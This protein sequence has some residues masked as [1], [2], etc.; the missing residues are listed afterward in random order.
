MGST[1]LP[2]KT[3]ADLGGLPVVDR[4][5]ARVRS[6][7]LVDEVVLAI[8]DRAEDDVLASHLDA[9]GQRYV[10]GSSDDV[11]SRF[12]LAVGTEP[13]AD[14]IIRITADCPLID[15]DVIDEVIA[16][17][18]EAPA[19][20]YCSNTL[21]RTYPIG[22][23]TEVFSRAALERAAAEALLPRER[24]HVTPYLYQHPMEFRLRNVEAPGWATWPELRLTLDEAADLEMLRALAARIDT[25]AGLRDVL[26]ALRDAP[27]IA[28]I[29]GQVA[30][31]HTQK[32][33]SW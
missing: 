33:G 27:E 20:D 21:V 15:P 29:N 14:T 17:S 31:R 13:D 30:H 8:T 7:R 9:L 28:A 6:A 11:L 2:G 3:L 1:R 10:R 5:I 32:P 18:S 26:G 16:A 22:M 25:D 12:A 24:E 19:I 23:D 4:V